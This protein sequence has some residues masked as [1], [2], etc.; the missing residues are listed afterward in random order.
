M[1]FVLGNEEGPTIEES[2]AAATRAK[3]ILRKLGE[4]NISARRCSE[5][6]VALSDNDRPQADSP[7]TR[8]MRAV[9]AMEVDAVASQARIGGESTS[10]IFGSASSEAVHSN[11]DPDL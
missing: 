5:S 7:R 3:E 1:L 8:F 2:T 10:N 11:V 4:T 9:G 6:L